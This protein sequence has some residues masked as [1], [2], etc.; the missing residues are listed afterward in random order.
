LKKARKNFCSLRGGFE[1]GDRAKVF[2]VL[3]YKKVPA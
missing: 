2:W 3:F 1:A